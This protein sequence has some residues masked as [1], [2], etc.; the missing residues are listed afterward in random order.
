M[1]VAFSLLSNSSMAEIPQALSYKNTTVNV[2]SLDFAQILARVYSAKPIAVPAEIAVAAHAPKTILK[3]AEH[4]FILTM[5]PVITYKNTL[6]DTRYLVVMQ[7][8]AYFDGQIMGCRACS[9]DA[10]MLIFRQDQG[11]YYLL[12]STF[13]MTDLPGGNGELKLDFAQI[14]KNLQP[15]GKQLIG[16]YFEAYFSGAGGQSSSAWYA[17]HLNEQQPIKLVF[18]ADAGGD[19]RDYYADRP[20][21]A[22]LMTSKL[23]LFNNAMQ[24]YPIDII[25]RHDVYKKKATFNNQRF[26]FDTT[27]N[28]YVAVKAK[29]N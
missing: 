6:G 1:F 9:A 26:V 23:N 21:M 5:L 24:Y 14:Q 2:T 7:K 4:D 8:N 15:F 17:L 18:I 13:N 16:S 10:D 25:Y 12:N 11:R 3:G 28:Q 19:T 27:K 20:E 29:T 22:S